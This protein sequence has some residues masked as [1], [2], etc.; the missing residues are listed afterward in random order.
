M[1][2]GDQSKI[3]SRNASLINKDSNNGGGTGSSGGLTKE[4]EA[5]V[6]LNIIANALSN[7]GQTYQL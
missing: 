7:E 3:R 1:R 4:G 6:S 2:Q 5:N